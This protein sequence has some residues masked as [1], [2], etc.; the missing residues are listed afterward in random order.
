MKSLWSDAEAAQFTGPLGLRVYTSRL[1]GRDRS[2]VLHGGG[3]TS[4]KLNEKDL[5]GEEQELLYVKGS[6]WDLETIEAPGFT[7]LPLGY[8]RRLTTLERLSDP[9]MVSE[10]A[11]HSLR[12]GAPAPSVETLLH[13]LLP[14][15]YVDHTHADAVLSISNSPDGEKRI[16]DIYGNRVVVIPYIM[17]GFDLAAYCARAFPK[18][19]GKSTLGM[20]LLSHGVFSFGADARESYE[21]MIE[22]VSLSE[23]YLEAKKAWSIGLPAAE[24]PAFKREEAAKLRH[25]V[26]RAAGFP[27]LCLCN[28]SPRFLAFARHAEVESISQ[29]GPATPDHVIR[30]KPVPMLGRDVNAFG[31]LYRKYF[32]KNEKNAKERK[33][34]LDA[35][36]RVALD[37]E[38]GFAAF[39][40]TAKDTRIAEDLY[41][42]TI[43]VI[44]RAEAL[45]GWRALE[46]RHTFDIEYW[47][48]EQAKLRKAG[49]PPAFTGE[50][51]L[52][53]G[54]ASG[55]GKACVESFL[56]RGAAVVG[57]DLNSSIE[58]LFKKPEFLGITCNLTDPSAISKS[59]DKA[60][61]QYGGIDMLVLNAGIFPASSPIQNITPESWRSAMTVNVEA[62]LLVMQ[63]CH[64]LLKLAPRGGR[65]VVI[66]SKNVPAPGP[67]AA[68][69]S[70]SKAALNQLARVA[71]LEWA[72]DGIRINTVH[73]NAVYDT[74][75]WTDEVLASRAKAYNLSVEQYKKN[76]LLKTEVSS[77][78]VAELAAEMCGALFAKTTA[79]QVPVDGGTERL[80]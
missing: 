61:R 26:S 21:R 27:M 78:D 50:V 29:R 72:K 33:T 36:P 18:E 55:I 15:K 54:A 75:L 4:V 77:K 45:G 35:A 73:P 48:L 65:V 62:S 51:A 9:Q 69:Y 52:V 44:L 57:L 43:D 53:T 64:A 68:A 31:V 80:V 79:A 23:R 66:G 67:G 6:G 56:R 7:P 5:F 12:A 46:N 28:D 14:H 41:E 70:A 25:E 74:A 1:L 30:T 32:E 42:H 22:L 47:D 76:N 17:A 13:A 8:L 40:R 38:L 20:V 37:R 39:G 24:A 63:A 58:G 59:L 71:A 49:A 10:L 19:A 60:V 16:R 34:M 2:L 11:T 3:N